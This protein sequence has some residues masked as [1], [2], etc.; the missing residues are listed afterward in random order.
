M[1]SHDPTQDRFL[2]CYEAIA[3]ATRRKLDAARACDWPAFDAGERECH[4]W[5]ERVERLG[6]PLAVLDSTGRRRRMELLRG[7]LRD[8]AALRELLQPWLAAVD[9]CMHGRPAPG[10]S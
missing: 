2:D 1:P 9:R 4:T 6:D 5:M 10:L 8:D 3:I 7:V